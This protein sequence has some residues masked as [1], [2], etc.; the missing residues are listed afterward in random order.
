MGHYDGYTQED[1]DALLRLL[2]GLR[3]KFLL[4]SFRNKSLSEYAKRN[5]WETLEIKMACPMTNNLKSP[6][7]KVEVL[8]A[9]YPISNGLPGKVL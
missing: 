2:E 1:F 9:N 6:R 7:E 3:G 5:G 8:T 4:S